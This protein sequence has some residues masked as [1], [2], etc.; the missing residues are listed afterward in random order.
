MRG[1]SY[2]IGAVAFVLVGL[3]LGGCDGGDAEKPGKPEVVEP[4]PPPLPDPLG[5][6][7]EARGE[8]RRERDDREPAPLS[9]DGPV[10]RE[11]TI[12][13]GEDGHATLRFH[14]T[15]DVLEL[16]PATRVTLP[17]QADRYNRASLEGGKLRARVEAAS[18]S[19]GMEIGTPVGKLIVHRDEDT[20]PD[21]GVEAQVEVLP[22]RTAVLM[23]EG[24]GRLER[25]RRSPLRI[26]PERFAEVDEEG[27][28]I[29]TGRVGPAAMPLEP[30]DGASFRTRGGVRFS[31]ETGEEAEAYRL[32]MQPA[33]GERI[34]ADVPSTETAAV[35]ELPAGEYTWVVRAVRKG[36]LLPGHAPRKLTVD[37]DRTPPRLVVS[38]P[39]NGA[40]V[41]EET[42]EIVGETEPGVTVE[43]DG[44]PVPVAEDGTFQVAR[45][46]AAGTHKIVVRAADD[47]GN[48]RVVTRRV[49]RK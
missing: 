21:G 25:T 46:I 33:E 11:D 9:T 24:R 16:G 31:W 49:T 15:G 45:P 22:Q 27:E 20:S 41:S 42:I 10:Y 7:L 3:G 39:E 34:R 8:V 28:I 14:E 17:V 40:T 48:F 26:E 43:V 23:V 32:E 44:D 37:L 18:K 29:D 5:R 38:G 36:S 13:T 4:P 6:A 1:K 35:V 30:E 2:A 19:E 12:V 47:L